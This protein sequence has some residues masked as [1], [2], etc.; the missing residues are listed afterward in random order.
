M[1]PFILQLQQLFN[2]ISGMLLFLALPA[3]TIIMLLR[4]FSTWRQTNDWESV[5]QALESIIKI[6]LIIVLAYSVLNSYNWIRSTPLGANLP[7]IQQTR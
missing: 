6:L 3:I 2:T 7:E 1:P 4:G 5:F